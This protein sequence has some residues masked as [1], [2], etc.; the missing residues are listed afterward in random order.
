MAQALFRHKGRSHPPPLGNPDGS[1]GHA[2]NQDRIIARNQP[3]ARYGI[4]E[5]RLAVAGHARDG[6]DFA[7][8]HVEIDILERNRERP[9]SLKACMPERKA[10][11]ISN[12]RLGGTN[13]MHIAPHHQLGKAR[14]RF[15]ARIARRNN[16]AVAQDGG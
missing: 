11:R 14:R 10:D 13:S 9:V 4:K 6:N 1:A 16:L 12:W 7:A 5:F 15:L 8:P 3:F 2:I